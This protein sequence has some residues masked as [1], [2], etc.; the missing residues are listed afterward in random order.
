M[1]ILIIGDSFAAD[2]S[3]K[4]YDLEGWPN[5]LSKNYN[6][7]NLAQAGVSEYKIYKQ[8]CSVNVT[9]FDLVIAAHTSP[10]RL[11]TKRHPIH[12]D[13]VLHA[14]CDLIYTDIEHHILKLKNKLNLSLHNAYWFFTYHYDEEYQEITHQLFREKIN[15]LLTIPTIT[16]TDFDDWEDIKNNHQGKCNHLSDTGNKIVYERILSKIKEFEKI[17]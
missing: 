10:Y 7:T 16:I 3:V 1:K 5:M 6:V 17:N 12:N 2:W 9:D 8:L 15:Y 11:V 13:D 4:Y 14:N